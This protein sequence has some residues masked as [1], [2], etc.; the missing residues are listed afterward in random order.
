M[1]ATGYL[2]R[3]CERKRAFPIKV[4]AE[5]EA[6]SRM[7]NKRHPRRSKVPLYV[8]QCSVC[9]LYHLT[10]RKPDP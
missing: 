10:K 4:K 2:K 6:L 7:N 1:S 9:G 8:Y 3:I 5:V